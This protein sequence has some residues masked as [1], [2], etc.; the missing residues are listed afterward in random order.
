MGFTTCTVAAAGFSMLLLVAC[1]EEVVL[2]GGIT[3]ESDAGPGRLDLAFLVADDPQHP[4]NHG[5]E[6]SVAAH[7]DDVVVA[8]INEH[9]MSGQTYAYDENAHKRVGIAVSHDGGRTFGST[10]DP[11]FGGET[12]DPVVR[13]GADGRF[14]LTTFHFPFDVM[15]PAGDGLL[16]AS[17]DRGDTWTAVVGSINLGDK[18]WLAVSDDEQVVYLGALNGYWKYRFDGVLLSEHGIAQMGHGEQMTSAYADASG[19]HFLTADYLVMDWSGS[20]PPVVSLGPLPGGTDAADVGF[21]ASLGATAQ[22]GQWIVRTVRSG[23][24]WSIVVRVRDA[25]VD[26]GMDLSLTPPGATVFFPVAVMDGKGRLHVV[27]YDSSEQQGVLRYA[28]S[29]SSDLFAGFTDPTVLDPD[30]CPGSG[31]HP[32]VSETE[33]R[34]REY[35]DIAASGDRLHVAW[36]HSPSPPSR[37]S[38]MS[39]DLD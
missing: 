27:W 36:T 7:G 18:E 13:V 11:G 15:L 16:A 3:P 23:A 4:F 20:A 26:Q 29:R 31:W 25:G 12:T 21:C 30:A 1:G 28:R 5:A 6:V 2:D 33:R 10:R 14:W 8:F 39:L 37:I 38:V 32:E 22:D 35:I 19:A 17:A 34:L 24:S 9:R